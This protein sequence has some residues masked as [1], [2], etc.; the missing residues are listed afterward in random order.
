MAISTVNVVVPGSGDGPIA[1]ISTLVGSKTVELTGR[2]SGRYV[3]LGSHNGFTF[4]PILE[5]EAGGEESIKQTLDMALSFVR[6]RAEAGNP[7]GV[8]LNISG[9]TSGTNRF[10]TLGTYLPGTSGMQPIIDLQGMFPPTSVELDLNFI[11]L[12]GFEGILVVRGSMDG[13]HFTPM[14]SFRADP[15]PIYQSGA[16]APILDFSPVRTKDLI[17][18]IQL[19]LQ[20][21]VSATTVIS[22][23]G[24]NPASG[25]GGTGTTTISFTEEEGRVAIGATEVIL[26]EWSTNLSLIPPAQMVTAQIE[27]IIQTI[28]ADPAGATFRVYV[29]STTPGDTVGGT[30]RATINTVTGAEQLASNTGAAFANPGGL[31]LVQVTGQAAGGGFQA[32]IRSASVVIS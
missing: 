8:T 30:L 19:D 2:F 24:A 15:Q 9:V 21:I 20:G 22:F 13:L 3:L 14:A 7:V 10:T 4:T 6:L 27:A 26:Y 25:G 29:G 28:A 17:R 16:P 12:G 31:R 5:F 1:D 18:F 23:G 32:A 11:C